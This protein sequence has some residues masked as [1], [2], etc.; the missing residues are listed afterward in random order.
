MDDNTHLYLIINYDLFT[1]NLKPLQYTFL[2]LNLLDM[3][4]V[5]FCYKYQ[6]FTNKK[7]DYLGAEVGQSIA[8][9]TSIC[10]SRVRF[11]L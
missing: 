4:I 11:P 2:R 10:M 6:N 9:L 7:A 8:L 1:R 5:P 3:Q